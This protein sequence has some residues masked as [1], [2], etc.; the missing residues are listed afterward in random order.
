MVSIR[1]ISA[2][3][4]SVLSPK[5]PQQET[6]LAMLGHLLPDQCSVEAISSPADAGRL[7]PLNLAGKLSFGMQNWMLKG[8]IVTPNDNSGFDELALALRLV[9]QAIEQR[10]H[11]LTLFSPVGLIRRAA[12][13][14][15]SDRGA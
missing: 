11:Q 8:S 1:S 4:S 5:S 2:L 6:Q 12:V 15:T 7:T 14:E 10:D 13:M 9:L 3:A